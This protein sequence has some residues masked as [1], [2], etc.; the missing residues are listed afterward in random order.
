[1]LRRLKGCGC[2]AAIQGVHCR[3]LSLQ[4]VAYLQHGGELPAQVA[5]LAPW[6]HGVV[7][8]LVVQLESCLALA[9]EQEAP[10]LHDS[11]DSCVEGEGGRL[12]GLQGH[13]P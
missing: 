6:A 9:T 2:G 7:A 5:C 4:G 10:Q 13:A 8:R 11:C 3:L 1:M 12:G